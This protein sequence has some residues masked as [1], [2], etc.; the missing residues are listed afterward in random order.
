MCM[1]ANRNKIQI[2]FVFISIAVLMQ[3]KIKRHLVAISLIWFAD[4]I[5]KKPM[6]YC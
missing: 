3:N 4:K 6:F 5:N 2:A 1:Q